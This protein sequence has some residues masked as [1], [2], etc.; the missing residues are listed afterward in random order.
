MEAIINK[1]KALADKSPENVSKE[2]NI[3]ITPEQVAALGAFPDEV[4]PFIYLG[5]YKHQHPESKPIKQMLEKVIAAENKLPADE[6]NYFGPRKLHPKYKHFFDE[7]A[8]GKNRGFVVAQLAAATGKGSDFLDHPD[9]AINPENTGNKWP[10]K[11]HP[12]YAKFF[13]QLRAGKNRGFVVANLKAE[14]G[15]N[16]DFLDKPDEP[17]E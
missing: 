4:K 6:L 12:K 2:M 13:E 15:K 9:D 7:L 16:A 10:R 3:Q 11:M 8:A 17:V 1:Y 5:L 14:T